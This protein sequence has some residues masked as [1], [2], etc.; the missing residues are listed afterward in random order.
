MNYAFCF[1]IHFARKSINIFAKQRSKKIFN[2][3]KIKT[4]YFGAYKIKTEEGHIEGSG[5]FMNHRFFWQRRNPHS[6]YEYAIDYLKDK[7]DC[8]ET[9]MNF[10]QFNKL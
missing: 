10:T 3:L 5:I 1:L 7:F 9:K 6:T 2:F 4:Y 8:D